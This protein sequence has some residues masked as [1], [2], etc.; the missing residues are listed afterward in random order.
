MR[1]LREQGRRLS[2]CL[3][4]LLALVFACSFFWASTVHR[5][6]YRSELSFYAV[7]HRAAQ[8]TA[9]L[10]KGGDFDSVLSAHYTRDYGVR[11]MPQHRFRTEVEEEGAIVTVVVEAKGAEYAFR[12]AKKC[13][14]LAPG[15][16]RQRHGI[17]LTLGLTPQVEWGAVNAYEPVFFA[18]S[19][20][21]AALFVFC[22][23]AWVLARAV[24]RQRRRTAQRFPLT[25]EGKN[26]IV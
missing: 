26:D 11:Y 2:V 8:D 22:L 7:T 18:L 20:T 1:V 9:A 14:L 24:C 16:F 21:L 3:C 4:L 10:L 13:A 25:E 15:F 5:N 12:I 17:S 23:C 19:C 6:W